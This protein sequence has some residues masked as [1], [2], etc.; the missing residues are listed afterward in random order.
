MYT[1]CHFPKLSN[2]PYNAGGTFQQIS[3]FHVIKYLEIL[4]GRILPAQGL[5]ALQPFNLQ[6]FRLIYLLEY[7]LLIIF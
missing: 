4:M 6:Q 2:I 5:F 3:N 7:L 1:S